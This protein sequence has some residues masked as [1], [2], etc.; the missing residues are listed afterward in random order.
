MNMKLAIC[1]FIKISRRAPQ[2]GRK[3][4]ERE[5]HWK[6]AEFSLFENVKR[7]DGILWLELPHTSWC[8]RADLA[9][10]RLEFLAL[11]KMRPE[12]SA[13]EL[14]HS[15]LPKKV[16]PT[17]FTP[18]FRLKKQFSPSTCDHHLELGWRAK[19]A[20]GFIFSA[21][22]RLEEWKVFPFRYFTS[23]KRRYLEILITW[24]HFVASM[25]VGQ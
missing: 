5:S 17:S 20:Q 23:P 22:E 19:N 1:H 21:P 7:K 13:Q 6:S 2:W 24:T 25:W 15:W 8:T 10:S 11:S 9:W 16:L 4:K 14:L 18:T 3:L 12:I